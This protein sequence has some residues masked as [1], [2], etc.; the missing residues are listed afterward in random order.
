V[1]ALL[2]LL[3]APPI[4][5]ASKETPGEMTEHSGT[6]PRYSLEDV[7]HFQYQD[8]ILRLEITFSR[9]DFYADRRELH[10]E[11]CTFVYY[12]KFGVQQSRGSS[13][14]A[15]LMEDQSELIAQDDVVVISDVNGGVLTTEYLV[16]KENRFSTEK[17]VTITRENGDIIKGVGMVADVALNVVTIF[18]NVRGS[19]RTE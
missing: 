6:V 9:G 11:N 5:P 18:Q 14:R 1:Q 17:A 16:W 19:V 7:T 8:G 2:F 3:A 10:V 13:K 15:I 4:L 12:D